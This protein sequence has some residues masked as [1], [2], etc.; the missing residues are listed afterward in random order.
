M[1]AARND[2]LP[3]SAEMSAGAAKSY[4]VSSNWCL[5]VSAETANGRMCLHYVSAVSA[6]R[7]QGFRQCFGGCLRTV[8]S[9]QCFFN[10]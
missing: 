5:R 6:E 7:L 1:S 9:K 10:L 4:R 2:K 3:V 8:D